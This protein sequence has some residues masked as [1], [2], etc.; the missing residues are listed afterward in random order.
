MR[1][2]TNTERTIHRANK[3]VRALKDAEKFTG[4]DIPTELID[5]LYA[6]IADYIRITTN[7]QH[8]NHNSIESRKPKHY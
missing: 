4:Y 3:A 6:L 5:D 7:S 2:M 8:Y 1:N